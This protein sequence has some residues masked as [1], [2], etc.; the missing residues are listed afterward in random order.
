MANKFTPK[1]RYPNQ[2]PSVTQVLGVLRKIGLE[3]WFKANTAAF[4]DAESNKGKVVGRQIHQLI[5]DIIGGKKAT[6][7]TEYDEE[8]KNAINS[9]LKFSKEYPTIKLQLAEMKLISEKYG[10]NGTLDCLAIDNKELVI[11]D[12]KTGKCKDKEQPPVFDEYFAQIAAYVE[13]YNEMHKTNIKRAFIVV[14][15]KDKVAYTI[16]PVDLELLNLHF[17]GIF[18]PAIQIFNTQKLLKR[19]M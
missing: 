6:I 17:N 19:G 3:L 18:L 10:Y 4:C 11:L 12:W 16:K 2:L 13:A 7:T 14:F 8:V 15:A 1:E 5:Q 9:F